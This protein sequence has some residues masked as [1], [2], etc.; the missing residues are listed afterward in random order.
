MTEDALRQR[1]YQYGSYATLERSICALFRTETVV[2]AAIL[3]TRIGLLAD[4]PLTKADILAAPD[5]SVGHQAVAPI[6]APLRRLARLRA[7]APEAAGFP[8]T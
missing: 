8:V 6:G 1:S 5:V 3:A 4:A 7:P 2:Q